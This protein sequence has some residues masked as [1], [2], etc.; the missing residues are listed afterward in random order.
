MVSPASVLIVD[1]N[2]SVANSLGAILKCYGCKT[3]STDSGYGAILVVQEERFD[4]ALLD[5]GMPAMNGFKIMAELNRLSPFTEII[6]K[7]AHDYYH[8][9]DEQAIAEKRVKLLHKS[10]DLTQLISIL[11]NYGDLL[12]FIEPLISN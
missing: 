12:K 10:S 5:M 4:M 7:P 1:D 2:I 8:P 11:I 3:I 6:L 9:L